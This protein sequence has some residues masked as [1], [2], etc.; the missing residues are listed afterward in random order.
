MI[1]PTQPAPK[2]SEPTRT[3]TLICGWCGQ[4][5]QAERT[6]A[7]WCSDRCKMQAARA[8]WKKQDA[9]VTPVDRNK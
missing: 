5:F 6:F 9:S 4:P 1:T 3:V 7:R 2:A 8:R